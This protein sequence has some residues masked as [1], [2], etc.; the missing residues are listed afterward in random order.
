VAQT[1]Q[2]LDAYIE[3]VREVAGQVVEVRAFNTIC[4]ATSERQTA[5]V[6]MAQNVDAVIVVGGR[7]SANTRR[8]AELCAATGVP[9]HHIETA[10]EIDQS[11]FEGAER[12]G[13]TAGASTPDWIIED[14]AERI[15]RV[16]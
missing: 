14:V 12:V 16:P 7:N 8:L 15:A 6:E 3:I 2:T 4:H 11:W 5:A 13:L 1:T 9:T 10:D